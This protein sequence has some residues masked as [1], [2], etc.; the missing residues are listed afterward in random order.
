MEFLFSIIL[1]G[2]YA[3]AA[4]RVARHGPARLWLTASG[5]LLLIVV[6]GVLLGRHYS[7]PSSP[8]LLLYLVAL[9]GPIVVFPT[10]LLSLVTATRSTM[11]KAFPTA[12]LGACFGFL[13]G[14]VIV[15]WGLGIW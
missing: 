14:F 13:C 3:T 6:G 10:A 7:V 5:F 15:V 11:A 8:R 1:V 4:S 12:I 2:A 9:T